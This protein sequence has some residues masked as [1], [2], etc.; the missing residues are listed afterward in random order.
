MDTH[1]V[2]VEF[3]AIYLARPYGCRCSVCG[4]FAAHTTKEEAEESK[5]IH[6][7]QT[8]AWYHLRHETMP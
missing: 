2:T 5:V 6:L 8:S 3:N 1:E 4:I 7:E